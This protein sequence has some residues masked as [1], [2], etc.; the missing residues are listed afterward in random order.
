MTL[1]VRRGSARNVQF[2][3][4]LM[5]VPVGEGAVDVDELWHELEGYMDIL[6]GR[7]DPPVESPYLGLM[8]CATAYYARALEIDAIIHHMEREGTV[9]RGHALYKFRTG[10]LR[11]FIE[12][13]KR[14]AEL[15]SRRLSQ[16][17]LLADQRRNGSY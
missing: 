7:E 5:G 17:Q 2:S 12:L 4:R 10:S 8:E 1:T 6:L 14:C 13:A 9:F 15:G 11:S 3:T 16:E